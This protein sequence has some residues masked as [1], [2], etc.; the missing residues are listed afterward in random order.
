MNKFWLIHD[1]G[2]NKRFC[3]CISELED[4]GETSVLSASVSGDC[5]A[6]Y[7]I[8]TL[9]SREDLNQIFSDAKISFRFSSPDA[10]T[11]YERGFARGINIALKLT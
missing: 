3:H 5:F 4:K 2:N 7:T 1:D 11:E 8:S 9:L 6:H 10:I